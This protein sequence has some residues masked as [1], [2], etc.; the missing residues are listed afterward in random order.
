MSGGCPV[1]PFLLLRRRAPIQDALRHV[2]ECGALAPSAPPLVWYSWLP[3]RFLVGRSP[4]GR[5]PPPRLCHLLGL[6]SPFCRHSSHGVRAWDRRRKASGASRSCPSYKRGCC[7]LRTPT[8]RPFLRKG[9][10]PRWAGPGP[11]IAPGCCHVAVRGGGPGGARSGWIVED[12]RR[13]SPQLRAHYSRLGRCS[14]AP[15]ENPVPTPPPGRGIPRIEGG[16][17]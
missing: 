17:R 4:C 5:N 3:P 9:A 14:T 13:G 7:G 8:G 11:R 6:L 1:L 15:A 10:P 12:C 2:S 16:A